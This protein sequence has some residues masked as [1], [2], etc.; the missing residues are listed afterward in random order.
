MRTL[1]TIPAVLLFAV[2]AMCAYHSASAAP[3]KNGGNGECEVLAANTQYAVESVI[4][5][6]PLA[7]VLKFHDDKIDECMPQNE[8]IFTDGPQA[9][10]LVNGLI[11]GLVKMVEA[12]KLP[13][14]AVGNIVMLNCKRWQHQ[15]SKL[16]P[17][18][19][20]KGPQISS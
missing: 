12:G 4:N 19:E 8:C 3:L 18:I 20:P 2:L 6:K 5:G 10:A 9:K 14:D 11:T 1:F 7:D 16:P 15:E 13:V 17:G